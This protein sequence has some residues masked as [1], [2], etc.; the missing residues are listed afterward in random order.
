MG[1]RAEYFTQSGTTRQTR[2]EVDREITT[3]ALEKA[4]NGSPPAQFLVH[5]SGFVVVGRSGSYTFSTTSDDGSTVTIDGQLV[6]DNRGEHPARTA[7]GQIQLQSGA[8]AVLIDYAQAGGGYEMAWA[9]AR[10]DSALYAVPSWALWTRRT[11]PVA[12]AGGADDR[13]SA[14][15]H[16]GRLAAGL[17]VGALGG[18]GRATSSLR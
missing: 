10:G 4:W 12:G 5:W 2:F 14:H 7:T 3:S 6:V 1:L 18:E 9:W 17:G 16:A 13:A 8:H 15:S 11:S